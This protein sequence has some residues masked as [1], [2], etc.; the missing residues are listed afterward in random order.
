MTEH[1]ETKNPKDVDP[2]D[3]R[4]QAAAQT[5]IVENAGPGEPGHYNPPNPNFGVTHTASN[6]VRPPELVKKA[7]E[8]PDTRSPWDKKQQGDTGTGGEATHTGKHGKLTD[9][10]YEEHTVPELREMADE[11][12]IEIK[13][14]ARKDEIIDALKKG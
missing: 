8:I 5:P 6:E 7:E 4:N 14:D 1:K 12:G 3:P 13:S 2:N 10:Q 9:E 11:R